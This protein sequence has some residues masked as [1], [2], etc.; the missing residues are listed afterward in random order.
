[1]AIAFGIIYGLSCITKLFS[2][3]WILLLGRFTGGIATSLL[4]SVFE[5]WMV[6]EH[7]RLGFDQN[8]LNSIFGKS[9]TLNA[10]AAI[11]AGLVA[12]ISAS[13]FGF[14][15]PFVVSLIVLIIVT[16][17]IHL[18]WNE[19][20]GDTQ[21]EVT[22]NLKN[23]FSAI[24]SNLS[25]LLLGVIQSLFE[26]SMYVF[27]FLW[28][29]TLSAVSES[30]KPGGSQYLHGLVFSSFMLAIMNGSA[31]FSKLS[32]N[33]TPVALLTRILL[34][35]ACTLFV[36]FVTSNKTLLILSFI[37]FEFCCGIY[38][39]TVASIRS[40]IIP[41]DFRS[42]IMSIFRVGLNLLV[43]I[44]LNVTGSLSTSTTFFIC[45]IWLLIASG[46][47]LLF[48][49]ILINPAQEKV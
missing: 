45:T 5:T 10:M 1:M 3:F 36:P 38:F 41:E 25:I 34:C 47:T 16:V 26:G 30:F 33:L 43:I 17:I 31:V 37:A 19:N 18:H 13:F 27:V 20:Y 40:I 39:P 22:V 46:L 24:R 21:T 12:S 48:P 42:T 9:V 49:T 29:P 32:K 4:F 23:A 6:S 35:A 28:T 2:S 8:L 44:A 14:V 7:H 15:A 11:A